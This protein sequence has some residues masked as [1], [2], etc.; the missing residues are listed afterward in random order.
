MNM[1]SNQQTH[2]DV[3]PAVPPMAYQS[4]SVN[5][6]TS[7]SSPF[8]YFFDPRAYHTVMPSNGL[9]S[10]FA[11]S[12][13]SPFDA[14]LPQMNPL[15]LQYMQSMAAMNPLLAHPMHPPNGAI[16]NTGPSVQTDGPPSS[17]RSPVGRQPNDE[18]VLMNALI[19]GRGSGQSDRQ[20]IQNGLHMVSATLMHPDSLF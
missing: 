5:T 18:N 12:Q 2:G 3:A 1:A 7:A 6:P 8:T 20:I 17:E 9:A 16:Q 11:L 10:Q 4:F 15:M 19:A 13:P 14:N